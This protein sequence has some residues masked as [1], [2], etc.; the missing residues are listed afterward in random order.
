MMSDLI[1]V[2]LPGWLDQLIGT[3]ATVGSR[4]SDSDAERLQKSLLVGG[5]LL[6]LPTAII[7]GALYLVFDE[8]LAG[9]ITLGYAII[10][11]LSI[12]YLAA[13]GR[14]QITTFA[15]LS[16]TLILPF[17]LTL[18]LG[19]LMN[20]S[21][22]ILGALMA[23][24]GALLY[25]NSRHAVRWFGAYAFL[26]VLAGLLNTTVSQPNNL[27][28]WLIITLTV[29]NIVIVSALAFFMLNSF[30]RQKDHA[31]LLLNE[32]QKRSEKLLL[33][34]LPAKIAALLK[35]SDETIAERF[36]SVSVLF[37]DVVGFTQLSS[38][39]DAAEL[40]ELLNEVFSYF[41]VLAE[42]Y[43]VEKIRTIG[44]NYMVAAGVPEPRP[45]HAQALAR[46]A[47]EML[48]YVGQYPGRE[49]QLQFRIGINSGPVV[50]GVIGQ[51][52]F[53]YDLWGDVVNVASRMESHGKPGE[54]Q[55]SRNTY[56]LLPEEF[57]CQPRGRIEVKGK[58]QME[59][60]FLKGVAS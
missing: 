59:T 46:L 3:L 9:A 45:D 43:G 40:V 56:E 7:W 51:R 37:A 36:D 17:I 1:Q 33:N 13:S 14:H 34:I 44:D 42:R 29:L 16:C 19:G 25:A 30:I 31:L 52:K 41:D 10:S 57:L 53:Q 23:P 6:I 54:I 39:M 5:S 4:P 24:L 58:G 18:I 8:P 11:A 55:I 21:L 28:E 15:Q 12:L 47:L 2:G 22:V 49:R 60:W 35:V 27:P 38:R 32:E 26:V 48:E 20:S 50:A